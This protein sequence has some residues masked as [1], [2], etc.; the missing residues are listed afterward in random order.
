MTTDQ[1]GG[2]ASLI[3]CLLAAGKEKVVARMLPQE[4]PLEEV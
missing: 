3:D 2:Q 1:L 4:R